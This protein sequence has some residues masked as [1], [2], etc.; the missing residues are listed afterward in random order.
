VGGTCSTEGRD[1]YKDLVG[2][3]E[4]TLPLERSRRNGRIILISRRGLDSS[5]S[6]W[7]P[8][9]GSCEH[10]N[11][12]SGSVNGGEFLYHLSEHKVMK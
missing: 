10:G 12:P 1:A 9:A 3:R 8:V 4:G 6:G 2:K 7:G 11:G 5:A